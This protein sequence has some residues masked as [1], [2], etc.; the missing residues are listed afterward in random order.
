MKIKNKS[1]IVFLLI[2]IG[3][4]SY[5]FA[6]E[7]SLKAKYAILVEL[8]TGRIIYEKNSTEQKYPAS[9]TKIMTAILVLENCNLDDI[10]TVSET[11]LSN[12]PS[13]YVTCDL[14]VGEEITIEDLLYALMVKSANDAAYVL[15]EHVAGSVDAFSDMMNMKAREIGCT[16]T[17]FVNP[18]GIHDDRHYTTAYDMYLMAKYGMENET[19]RKLV[20]TKEYT[21]H[22]TN[23]YPEENRSF[24]TTNDLIK[25][26]SSNYYKYAIGIKT[27]YTTDAG[28]CLV[29]E[30]SRDGLDF[31]AVIMDAGSPS[32]GNRFKDAIKL[33]DYAYENY[34]LTK[35]KEPNTIVETIEI[36]NGNK[37]T[38]VLNVLIDK[39][40]TIINNKS[41]DVN[42]LIPEIKYNENLLAPIN[43]GDKIGTIKYK[44]DDIEYSA[45]LIAETDVIPKPDYGIFI[46][47]A[48]I[49]L[50]LVGITG[51]HRTRKKRVRKRR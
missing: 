15:A 13:G 28:E 33:F 6:D 50:L 40:I 14:R 16:G 30:S 25:D 24:S 51:I 3:L 35:I 1:L 31:I 19:F 49:V 18:N 22:S 38:K 39:E 37:E 26:G 43:K 20:S 5:V 12:I 27:G 47:I 2:I 17:H 42:G 9:I 45:G 7:I 34:T 11:A 36:E 44:V 48:G 29:A 10:A 8:S 41:L 4:N 46:V 32:V 21:L 23:M